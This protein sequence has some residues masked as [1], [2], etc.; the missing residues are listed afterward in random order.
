MLDGNTHNWNV[1]VV[2]G[3]N[4]KICWRTP[5]RHARSPSVTIRNSQI[6]NGDL[7]G[8][9]VG[10]GSGYQIINN[11]FD[12]LCDRGVNH[13][14]NMQ[15]DTAS[16]RRCGS[17]A[18]TFTHGRTCGTQGITSYDHGTNGVIIENNVSTSA[19]VGHRTVL[20]R[21]L[22]VRHNT[23][24]ATRARMRFNMPCGRIDVTH[25][26]GDPAA[27]GTQV[28]DNVADVGVQRGSPAAT[29]T[30]CPAAAVYVGPLTSHNGF[31]CHRVARGRDRV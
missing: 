1:G 3:P 4:A 6:K 26:C 14:D 10:G 2:G 12:N 19:P 16:P 15:F 13:T 30:T 25:K 23:V 17:Q 18:T 27:T 11:T 31:L 20:R 8:I 21:E 9:H 24:C 7:D 5:D 29:T 22:I 28:Y